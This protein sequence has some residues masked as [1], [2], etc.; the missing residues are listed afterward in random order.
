MLQWDDLRIFLAVARSGTLSKAALALG[1]RQ[2]TVGRRLETLE[3]RAGAKLLQK[4]PSGYALTPAGQ[5]IL[6]NVEKIEADILAVTRVVDG[7]DTRLEGPL[8]LTTIEC[9]AARVLPPILAEFQLAFPRIRLEVDTDRRTL[10]LTRREADVALRPSALSQSEITARKVGKIN[11]GL[12]ASRDYLRSHGVPD[13]EGG[14]VGHSIILAESD[15]MTLQEMQWFS[16][17]ANA[18]DVVLRSNDH[19]FQLAAVQAGVGI[20]CLPRYL[21]DSTNL[22]RLPPP[23]RPPERDL[24]LATHADL[25]NIPR[26][27]AFTDFL[28]QALRQ[29][30]HI[31]SPT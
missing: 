29:R 8:R 28:A 10:S 18:A 13:W 7:H 14:A 24:W 19:H 25:R 20:A 15:L 2:T 11:F 30:G 26:I 17:Q 3:E 23:E 9:L 12:F 6:D 1:V 4:T 21:G 22:V 27:R 16:A 31:L 5:A